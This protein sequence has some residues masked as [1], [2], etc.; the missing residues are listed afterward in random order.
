MWWI[1][2]TLSLTVLLAIN[3]VLGAVFVYAAYELYQISKPDL[4]DTTKYRP[5]WLDKFLQGVMALLLILLVVVAVMLA[6]QLY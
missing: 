5:Q 1:S 6:F 4:N 2:Q 3:A